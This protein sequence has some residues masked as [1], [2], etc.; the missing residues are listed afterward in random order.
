MGYR[1]SRIDSVRQQIQLQHAAC[2]ERNPIMPRHTHHDPF[3]GLVWQAKDILPA[4]RL[5]YYGK[6]LKKRPAFISLEYFP[7][8]YTLFGRNQAAN[9]YLA[10]YLKGELSTAAKNIM[11]AL[12]ENSPQITRDLK[13]STGMSH[14]ERR[15]Q[16]DQAMAELQM[17]MYAVKIAEFYEPFTFLWDLVSNQF[18]LEIEQ[19]QKITFEFAQSKILK[20]YFENVLVSNIRQIQLL[21]GWPKVSIAARLQ[22]LVAADILISDVAITGK[23]GVW[24]AIQG[25]Q[26]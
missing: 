3:I 9:A 7:Y 2:G 12:T 23:S 21:F 15:Y 10:E 13:L 11:D 6:A 14:P 24:Y 26:Y 25:E 20:K 4:K 8:F 18:E 22:E 17:K 5:V 1:H 16:F 19:T